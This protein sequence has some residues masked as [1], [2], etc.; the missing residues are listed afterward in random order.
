MNEGGRVTRVT[1]IAYPN[2]YSSL[3]CRFIHNPYALVLAQECDDATFKLRG[4]QREL[5][6]VTAELSAKQAEVGKDF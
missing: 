5:S 4:L 3:M 1:P 6:T 2:Y